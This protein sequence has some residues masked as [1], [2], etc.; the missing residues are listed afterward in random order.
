[1]RDSD[2]WFV[3]GALIQE[4]ALTEKQVHRGM[5]ELERFK[6]VE[7]RRSRSIEST[8]G[9]CMRLTVDGHMSL[10]GRSAMNDKP[11]PSGPTIHAGPH[12]MIYVG[13]HGT[14]SQTNYSLPALSEELRSAVLA[15]DPKDADVV[16]TYEHEVQA[17]KPTRSTLEKMIAVAGATANAVNK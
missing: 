8:L 15:H 4:L 7:V 14:Q 9:D 11:I 12:S 2:D 1:M 6:L 5:N 16:A 13:D 10:E 17:N 3:D